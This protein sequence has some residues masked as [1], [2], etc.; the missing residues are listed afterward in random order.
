MA[1]LQKLLDKFIVKY[2]LCGRCNYPEC[3]HEVQKKDLLAN[4]KS[5]GFSKKMDVTHKAGKQMMK[6]IPNWNKSNAHDIVK[7][8]N[9]T[10]DVEDVGPVQKTGKR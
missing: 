8:T 4:C 2:V 6:E 3:A 1:D 10:Q 7:K 9:V 5:C